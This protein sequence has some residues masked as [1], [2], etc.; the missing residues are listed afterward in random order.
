MQSLN[1]FSDA[2]AP[3]SGVPQGSDLGPLLFFI[4]MNDIELCTKNYQLLLLADD[5]KLSLN[6]RSLADCALLQ[7][8]VSRVHE[9]CSSNVLLINPDKTEV[10]LMCRRREAILNDY[11]LGSTTIL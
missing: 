2:Y 9:W 7:D 8:D 5:S 1:S 4:F 6:V 10:T 11:D 3:L